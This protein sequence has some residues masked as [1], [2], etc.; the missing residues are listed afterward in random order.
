MCIRDSLDWRVFARSD[1]FYVKQ[2]EEE[3]NLNCH[4]VLDKSAS[5]GYGSGRLTKLQYA[6]YLSAA[7]AYFMMMQRDAT[8]LAV[9]DTEIRAL[10]PPRSRQTHLHLTLAELENLNPAGPTAAGKPLHDLAEGIKKR[11]LIVLIS[12]LFDEPDQILSGLQHFKFLGNDVIVFHIADPAELEFPFDRLTEFIDPETD[13]HILTAP[14]QVRQ[15]YLAEMNAFYD[16]Y[17]QGCADL[18]VDYKLLDTSTPLELALSEYLF[19]RSR[20]Y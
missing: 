14:G 1:R 17:R 18:R 20:R 15:E 2:Y 16:I 9:F 5:M 13:E 8:G 4:I 6:C 10:L 7:L 12:D 19:Q 3:T 11:G